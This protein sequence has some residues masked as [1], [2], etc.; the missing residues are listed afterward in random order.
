MRSN[1]R[2]WASPSASLTPLLISSSSVPTQAP[3]AGGRGQPDIA[4]IGDE[5]VDG[6]ADEIARCSKG[7]P[8]RI[9]FRE[10]SRAV[11]AR[12]P[13]RIVIPG[14]AREQSELAHGA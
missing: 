9:V 3:C 6:S 5:I 1:S 2:P 4:A 7:E 12:D 8:A 11:G 13:E 10:D 14:E